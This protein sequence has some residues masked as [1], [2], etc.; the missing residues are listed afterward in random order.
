MR[1]HV[2]YFLKVLNRL[3]EHE[4][5]VK[6][7]KYEFAKFEIMF[8]DHLIREGHVKID[9]RKIQAIIEWSAPKTVLE[10]RTF[11]GFTNQYRWLIE[12][13][14]KKTTYFLDLL[15]KNQRYK[16]SVDFH[17]TFDKLKTIIAL[18]L[19]LGLPN[20]EK[21]FKVYIDDSDRA[22]KRVLV[23]EEHLIAFES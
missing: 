7:E 2:I 23:Q 16:W 19:V 10:L 5:F 15:K 17:R 13:Y 1:D 12:G 14:N 22:I 18:T 3:K 4:L 21:P 6:G 20:F 11:L 8:L 9:P